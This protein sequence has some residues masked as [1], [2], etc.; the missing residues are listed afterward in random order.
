[1]TNREQRKYVMDKVDRLL[2]DKRDELKKKFTTPGVWLD[3]GERLKAFK[4]GQYKVSKG[5]DE[6]CYYTKLVNVVDF[7]G[8]KEEKFDKIGYGKKYD[9]LEKKAQAVK[10]E[11]MLGDAL[12][13]MKLLKDFEKE[14]S[15]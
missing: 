14:L 4:K 9:T 6:I 13:V 10:D 15:K 7:D 3:E 5:I 12:E 1:M 2:R 11:V 8:E